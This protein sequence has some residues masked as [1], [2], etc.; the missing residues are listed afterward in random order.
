LG[1]IVIRKVIGVLAI[2]CLADAASAAKNA[3]PQAVSR[4]AVK[5]PFPQIKDW[6]SLRIRLERTTCY[7]WCPAYSVEIGGDGSVSWFG[8]RFVDAK[9][10]RSSQ[11]PQEKVRA[12][13]DAFVKAD[14]FWTLDEY[15]APITDLPTATVTISFDGYQKRVVDYA[16]GH[17][18]M[19]KVID[20]LEDAIDALAGTKEWVGHRREP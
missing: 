17:V 18:G 7:G 14:F 12:L 1:G 15:V 11:V 19:P 13:Y 20:D 16:G 2:I 6:S 3:D 4:P 5:V 8:T 10:S 9:G